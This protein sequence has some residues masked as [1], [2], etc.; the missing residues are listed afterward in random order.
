LAEALAMRFGGRLVPEVARS[1][2]ENRDGYGAEDVLEIAR[3]Q[4]AAEEAALAETAGLVVCDTDLLVIRIWWE[5][6]FG[7]LPDELTM[8]LAQRH[9]R[10]YLLVQPDLPWVADSLRENPEDRDRLFDLYQAL[11]V[12][13]SKPHR[14][15]AGTGDARLEKAIEAAGALLPDLVPSAE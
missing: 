13:E 3:L 6:R 8:L 10:A 2:L 11:L 12:S 9:E 4:V 1:Y 15:V 14:V 5:E 7:G